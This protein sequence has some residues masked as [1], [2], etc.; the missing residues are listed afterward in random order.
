MSTPTVRRRRLGAKLRALRDDLSLT[1]EDV[2]EKSGKI[3]V[4]KLSRLE[5]AKTAAKSADV[6]ALLDLYGVEDG[7]LRA[8]LLA[9]TREGSQRGWW[10][11]YRGVLSPVYEDLIS[12]ESEA[13]TVR[14]WQMGVIPGLLQTGEYAR[15]FM[16][17]IG[18]S[19]AVE[20]K[21]DALVEVRLARQAVL[22]REQPLGLWAIVGEQ[23]LRTRCNGEGV[24]RDQ[25]ARLLALS[26]R[27]NVT[28]QVLPAD[29][30][31]HVGQMGSYSILGFET[32]ADLDVVHVESLTSALYVEDREQV[33]VYRDAF[34]RLCAAALPVEASADCITEIRKKFA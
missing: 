12:L 25:L 26:K 11:S 17:S 18:M 3:T 19:A 31:P 24:M 8:A 14:T 2:A 27:P 33:G 16:T 1:L 34:E 29:A 4:A 9:L 10:Q 5:I 7:E 6:E 32:H 30:P 20:E 13:T 21:V 15:E 28:I 22:T 23:A